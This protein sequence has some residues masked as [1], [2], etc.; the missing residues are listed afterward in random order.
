MVYTPQFGWL[1]SLCNNVADHAD[2]GTNLLL[3]GDGLKWL[4]LRANSNQIL[5]IVSQENA[6][7]KKNGLK[8]VPYPV[9]HGKNAALALSHVTQ[10]VSVR[11]SDFTKYVLLYL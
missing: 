2:T 7:K 3:A 9:Q 8:Y 6:N 11:T 4:T 5:S 1:S 10:Q